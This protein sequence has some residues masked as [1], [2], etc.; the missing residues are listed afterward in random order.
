M[1]F[2]KPLVDSNTWQVG[3]GDGVEGEEVKTRKQTVQFQPRQTS[4]IAPTGVCTP[5]LDSCFDWPQGAQSEVH[6]TTSCH[7]MCLVAEL[8]HYSYIY[9]QDG[10][11]TSLLMTNQSSL[12]RSFTHT[13]AEGCAVAKQGR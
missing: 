12:G 5:G 10:E 11:H 4:N 7:A 13:G 2:S 3:V 1:V 6:G 9:G 8:R